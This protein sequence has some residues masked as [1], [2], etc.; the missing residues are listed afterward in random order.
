MLSSDYA[1]K[2]YV[3]ICNRA[4]SLNKD[5][6]PFKQ[7]LNAIES[8]EKNKK[9]EVHIAGQDSIDAYVFTIENGQINLSPHDDCGQCQCERK[10]HLEWSYLQQVLKNPEAYIENP[11]KINWDWMH[12][13]KN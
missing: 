9:I 8:S 3:S 10:W 5:R 6:F 7:I 11:A 13:I 1:I 12:D 4:L 2:S